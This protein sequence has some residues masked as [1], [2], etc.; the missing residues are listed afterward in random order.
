MTQNRSRRQAWS[1]VLL[2]AAMVAGIGATTATIGADAEADPEASAVASA[3]PTPEPTPFP[4]FDPA[5][6][7]IRLDLLSDSL[8]TPVFVTDD[9]AGRQCVYVVERGGKVFAV[10]PADGSTKEKPFLDISKLV[11]VGA[12]QGLHSIA[13]HPEFATNGRL[14]AHYNS[15]RSKG[16]SVVAEFRGK[17]CDVARGKPIKSL[18]V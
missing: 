12:E 14:F 3:A 6:T 17:S 18:F 8:D 13:F 5:A 2:A 9:G 11:V 4:T 7:P 15:A 16:S 1:G 10:D